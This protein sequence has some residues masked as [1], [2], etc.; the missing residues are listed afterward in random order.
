M[1]KVLVE[2]VVPSSNYCMTFSDENN[3]ACQ[4]LRDDGWFCFCSL[5]LKDFLLKRDDKGIVKASECV[6]LR[7]ACETPKES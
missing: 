5:G 6:D 4:H 3:E 7:D 2:I 1:K